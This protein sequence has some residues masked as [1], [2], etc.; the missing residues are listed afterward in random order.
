M[1]IIEK[2]IQ[3]L[4]LYITIKNVYLHFAVMYGIS[5]NDFL[6]DKIYSF[7]SYM[8]D[9][10]KKSGILQK[11]MRMPSKQNAAAKQRFM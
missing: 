6:W 1:N 3:S 11:K 10:R 8:L 4:V 2:E 5:R 9:G 7:G